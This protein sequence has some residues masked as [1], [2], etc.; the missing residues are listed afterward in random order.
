MASSEEI[1]AAFKNL[2]KKY[3]P[4]RNGGS[5][6][7]EERFKEVADAY[8]MISDT[9]K[10]RK[11]DAIRKMRL[12][13][14]A[15][16]SRSVDPSIDIDW[17]NMFKSFASSLNTQRGHST[18]SEILDELFGEAA[19]EDLFAT[20]AADIHLELSVPFEKS[21]KGGEVEISYDNGAPRKVK[22][23]IHPGIEDGAR[24]RL[25][26]EGFVGPQGRG[27][28]ILT[29]RIARDG[30]FVRKGRDVQCELRIN[31]ADAIL[32]GTV[33]HRTIQ[34]DRI[35]IKIPAGTQHGTVLR[36]VGLGMKSAEKT[37]DMFVTVYIEI[38][39]RLNKRQRELIEK[40]AETLGSD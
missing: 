31:V 39:E 38:P 2:A 23:T 21:V 13:K 29:I 14:G 22:V 35:D 1:K 10:R 24:M 9:D 25:R 4:D 7:A 15:G 20:D 40:F 30:N 17:H 18:F 6:V 12:G 32:G 3:H 27:D 37:G 36:L 5:K 11:Y 33:R 28:V 34:G 8:E 19:D 16:A 26:G